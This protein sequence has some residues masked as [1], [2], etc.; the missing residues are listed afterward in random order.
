MSLRALAVGALVGIVATVVMDLGRAIASRLGLRGGVDPRLTGR[1]FAGLLRG[2]IAHADI[3]QSE[4]VRLEMGIALA[5][6][7]AIGASLGAPFLLLLER[8]P[9]VGR[10]P[11]ALA[12][13]V[14]TTVFSWFVMFPSMGYGVAGARGP[15]GS[16]L[17]L[18]STTNHLWFGVGLALCAVALPILHLAP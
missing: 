15:A 16:R 7:Y 10:V 3:A 9:A 11:L 14:A 13:G 4:P 18:V 2:R 17:P 12:Y 6:H 8:A 5:G 1:W